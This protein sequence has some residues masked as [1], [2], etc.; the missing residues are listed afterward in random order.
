MPSW[1]KEHEQ[2]LR[3]HYTVKG[4]RWCAEQ[5]GRSVEATRMKAGEL[6]VTRARAS[7]VIP[8]SPQIDAIIR[9][10][11]SE[12]KWGA[13]GRAA[14][15]VGRTKQ[16]VSKRAGVLGLSLREDTNFGFTA[17]QIA[18]IAE[19]SHM[20]APTLATRLRAQ[21]WRGSVRRV[22]EHLTKF[23]RPRDEDQRMSAQDVADLFGVSSGRVHG[24]IRKGWLIAEKVE[25]Y[26]HGFRINEM[27]IARFAIEHSSAFMLAALERDK[28]WFL[29]LVGRFTSSASRNNGV[30]TRRVR[31]VAAACPEMRTMEI[32]DLLGCNKE[33]VRIALSAKPVL[34]K[35]AA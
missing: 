34:L 5:T 4:S 3:D 21:G 27:D 31:S 35:V 17:A 25:G 10:A 24:W 12:G 15:A 9:R 13:C 29:D 14:K 30:M 1:S 2:I 6:G 7:V 18:F 11:Y 28:S 8:T 26:A 22:Q 20:G 23:R 16:W 19:N 33:T 32:A